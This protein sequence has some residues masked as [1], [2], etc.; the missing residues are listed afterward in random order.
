MNKK[1]I[2][3][4]KLAE[5]SSLIVLIFFIPLYILSWLFQPEASFLKNVYELGFW[6][7]EISF[8]I[9]SIGYIFVGK[10]LNK[11]FI[12]IFGY[13]FIFMEI[14]SILFLGDFL[15]VL[16][17]N[18]ILFVFCILLFR[19][20]KKI[21]NLKRMALI[22]FSLVPLE[23]LLFLIFAYYQSNSLSLGFVPFI[24]F[25]TTMGLSFS[26]YLFQYK[27]FKE[28]TNKIKKTKRKK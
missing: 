17:A 22:G 11:R 8:I 21:E 6:I 25:L 9:Y 4:L 1:N 13:I 16:I 14:F 19:F 12:I 2:K 26:F 5:Y 20:I 18:S 3:W 23:I 24:L 27:F 7:F 28:L 10:L 15:N